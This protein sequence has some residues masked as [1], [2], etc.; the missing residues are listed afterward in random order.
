VLWR[1]DHVGVKQLTEDFAK[2]LYL[3]RLKDSDVLIVAI[4]DGVRQ[5][6]DDTFAYAEGWDEKTKR[7]VGLKAG[8]AARVILDARSVVVKPEV[9]KRQSDED[10]KKTTTTTTTTTTGGKEHEDEKEDKKQPPAAVKPKR[11]HATVKLDPTRM[12]RDAGQIAQEVVQHLT[13]L[14]GAE[15][16]VNLEIQAK[17]PDGVPDKTVRD[18]TENCR[19]LKLDTFEFEKE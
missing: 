12:A 3:P 5:L 6:T 10:A 8:V 4:E 16:E 9:A 13:T 17:L 18:V 1:G 2:Y 14:E 11:F 7:Y 19:T 15:V